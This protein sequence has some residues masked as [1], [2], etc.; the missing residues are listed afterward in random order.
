[1]RLPFIISF[2]LLAVVSCSRKHEVQSQPHTFTLQYLCSLK[3]ADTNL[4]IYYI[5][6][7][8]GYDWVAM[9]STR[10]PGQAIPE[11]NVPIGELLI[12]NRHEMAQDMPRWQN[13]DDLCKK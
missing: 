2:G 6:T 3:S 11:F 12:S 7:K 13:I 1:M 4:H 8:D 5:G 10:F 9:P